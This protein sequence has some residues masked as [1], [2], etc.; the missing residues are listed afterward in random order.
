[1]NKCLN[2]DEFHFIEGGTDSMYFAIAG[3][4]NEPSTRVLK[5]IITHRNIYNSNIAKCAPSEFF[6][7]DETESPKLDTQEDTKA[8]ENRL[9]YLAI[10]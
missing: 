8:H 7:G 6:V 1:M 3:E 5:S 9:I 4:P 10:E 2:V